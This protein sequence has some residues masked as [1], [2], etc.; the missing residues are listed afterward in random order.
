MKLERLEELKKISTKDVIVRQT[1][2]NIEK[3]ITI[4]N[5]N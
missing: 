5:M 4:I 2:N 3:N 1:L